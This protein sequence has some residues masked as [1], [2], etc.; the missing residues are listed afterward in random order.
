MARWGHGVDTKILLGLL[1]GSGTFAYGYREL[2]LNGGN[3]SATGVFVPG[4]TAP[5]AGTE[6]TT[7]IDPGSRETSAIGKHPVNSLYVIPLS[8][9]GD[10]ESRPIIVASTQ[11]EGL[12]SYRVRRDVPQWNG[13]DNSN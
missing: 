1:D 5:A 8:N 9:S 12:W 2:D 7:S 13:E 11:K 3:V 10:R 4:N 6:R